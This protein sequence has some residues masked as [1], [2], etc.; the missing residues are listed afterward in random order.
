LFSRKKGNPL[1][2]TRQ[3]V[4]FHIDS[5]S[6]LMAHPGYRLHRKINENSE[7][8]YL[9]LLERVKSYPKNSPGYALIFFSGGEEVTF[10]LI[11]LAFALILHP[12][13]NNSY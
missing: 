9:F 7:L 10:S 13:R 3:K 12:K 11:S 4:F 8:I 1:Y 2:Q 6:R 5:L